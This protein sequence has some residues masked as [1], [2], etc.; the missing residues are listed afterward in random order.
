MEVRDDVFQDVDDAVDE[1][2]DVIDDDGGAM[3]LLETILSTI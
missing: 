1:F 2:V 3:E